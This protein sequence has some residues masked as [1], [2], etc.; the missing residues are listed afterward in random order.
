MAMTQPCSRY[1]RSAQAIID[2]QSPDAPSPKLVG[3]AASLSWD[4]AK[5]SQ[6]RIDLS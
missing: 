5:S 1:N 6:P 3:S 4:L 2:P